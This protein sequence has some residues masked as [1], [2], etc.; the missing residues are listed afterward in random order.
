MVEWQ[1]QN[2][3]YDKF[4]L[5]PFQDSGN[6]LR[7]STSATIAWLPGETQSRT[8]TFRWYRNDPSQSTF[9]DHMVC[10]ILNPQ[11]NPFFVDPNTDPFLK[12][13]SMQ[14]D[15][16]GVSGQS[17]HFVQCD[18]QG[19]CITTDTAFQSVFLSFFDSESSGFCVENV[20]EGSGALE[21]TFEFMEGFLGF[22]FEEPSGLVREFLFANDSVGLTSDFVD[23]D[24]KLAFGGGG[25]T[26]RFTGAV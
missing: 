10:V 1:G 16:R 6:H 24:T 20:D 19:S 13:G 25:A 3:S 9:V 8:A 17:I 2:S 22:A 26:L 12:F 5:E 21:F 4:F 23:S 14:S 15:I 11:G 18:P 7:S